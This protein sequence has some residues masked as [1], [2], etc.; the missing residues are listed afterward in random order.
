MLFFNRFLAIIAH[1][2]FIVYQTKSLQKLDF[3][4]WGATLVLY[5]ILPSIIARKLAGFSFVLLASIV[6]NL[7][8]RHNAVRFCRFSDIRSFLAHLLYLMLVSNTTVEFLLV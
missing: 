6:P 7:A 4:I 3:A 5:K 2:V 1:G 8:V